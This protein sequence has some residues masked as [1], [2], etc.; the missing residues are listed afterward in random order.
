MP[1]SPASPREPL[2]TRTIVCQGYQ[3]ADGL[4]DIE[5][6]LTDVKAYAFDNARRGQVDAGTPVHDMWIRLTLDDDF[7]VHDVEAVTDASPYSICPDITVNS[8]RLKGL[9][10]GP[11]WRRRV[12]AQVGGVHGCTHLVELLGPIATTAYQTIH[13]AKARLR[14]ASKAAGEDP[15]LAAGRTD[16]RPRLLNTC[17]AFGEESPVVEKY[18]PR[19]FKAG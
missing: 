2:H 7:E 19:F 8:S 4:W 14:R 5:G 10:I 6:H 3:R 12:Q 11:G 18:W 17:H 16:Q 13:A 9:S 15:V 1:L